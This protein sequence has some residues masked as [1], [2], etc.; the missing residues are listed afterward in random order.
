[1]KLANEGDLTLYHGNVVVSNGN[2]DVNKNL[3]IYG[4]I[5]GNA[6]DR[7]NIYSNSD[8]DNSRAWIEMFGYDAGGRTGEL[9]LAG[10]Y[11]DLRYNSTT[12]RPGQTGLRLDSTGKVGIGTTS[13]TQ[14]L[15]VTGNIHASGDIC[16][17]V[18]GKCLSS[19]G[20]IWEQ[21]G[22]DIYYSA[23]SVGIGTSA[24]SEALDVV[25]DVLASGDI[26]AYGTVYSGGFADGKKVCTKDETNCP[27]NILPKYYSHAL[28]SVDC[29]NGNS[30]CCVNF[31]DDGVTFSSIPSVIVYQNTGGQWSTYGYGG[32]NPSGVN[33]GYWVT[34][35][36]QNDLCVEDAWSGSRSYRIVAIGE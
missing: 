30:L 36:T 17:D 33:S 19:V 1:M 7:L 29:N 35:L 13:P 25:G 20:G 18:N 28:S 24:P 22:S 6:D 26:T 8:A 14:K 32:I 2:V 31:I 4:D 21:T 34:S 10:T 12:T 15:D 11:V 5:K 3:N 27:T 23:G 9:A 16:T